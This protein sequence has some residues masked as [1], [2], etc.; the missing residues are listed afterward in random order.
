MSITC[1]FSGCDR[2][3]SSSSTYSCMREDTLL[4]T[5]CKVY[6]CFCSILLPFSFSMV[7]RNYF[8]LSEHIIIPG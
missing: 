3:Y 5:A 4:S 2:I 6:I 7:S 1:I 8:I